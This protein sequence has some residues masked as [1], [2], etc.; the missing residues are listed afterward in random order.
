[1]SEEEKRPT[2]EESTAEVAIYSTEDHEPD[3]AAP[4]FSPEDAP[5]P[6][7]EAEEAVIV[8]KPAGHP[9]AEAADAPAS[10]ASEPATVDRP[11]P[12]GEPVT[13]TEKKIGPFSGSMWFL[14]LSVAAFILAVILLFF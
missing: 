8:Q 13:D 5:L 12:A 7:A 6:A 11:I 4:A 9:V 1:M 10:V 14:I 3:A 2:A